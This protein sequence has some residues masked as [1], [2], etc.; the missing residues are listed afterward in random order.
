[1]CNFK[2]TSAVPVFKGELN[3]VISQLN[4]F[5]LYQG[6]SSKSLLMD[7]QVFLRNS[8]IVEDLIMMTLSHNV[9]YSPHVEAYSLLLERQIVSI[10]LLLSID[11]EC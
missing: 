7:H 11:F 1:M 2:D 10:T 5:Q 9:L 8:V 4:R 3:R 6:L